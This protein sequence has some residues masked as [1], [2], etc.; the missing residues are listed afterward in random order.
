[1][2]LPRSLI[3]RQT[4]DS[5]STDP[6]TSTSTDT[7][8]CHSQREFV[9]EHFGYCFMQAESTPEFPVSYS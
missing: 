8:D 5:A 3:L 7:T 6:L 4:A 1:M 9:V 2:A